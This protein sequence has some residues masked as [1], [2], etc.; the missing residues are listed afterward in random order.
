MHT[1]VG[2]I[3]E[4]FLPELERLAAEMQQLHPNLRFN[5]AHSPIGSLT[6]YQGHCLGV[7]CV[8]P[9]V[10]EN[11]SGNVA[12]S[13]DVCHLT[14]TPRLMADVVWGHPSGQ[15]EAEFRRTW[16]SNNEWPEATSEVVEELRETFPELIQAFRSAV[17]RGVPPTRA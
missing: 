11:V 3:E 12:L 13:L 16:Q 15:T 4:L 1:L 10:A 2:Q 6:G 7:E 14:S 5:L 17:R 9:R 8:F